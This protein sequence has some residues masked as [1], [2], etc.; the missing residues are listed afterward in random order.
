M[1]LA[2]IAL[3]L[4]HHPQRDPDSQPQRH[5]AIDQA[6][7]RALHPHLFSTPETHDAFDLVAD[8]AS[9]VARGAIGRPCSHRSSTSRSPAVTRKRGRAAVGYSMR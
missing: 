6:N 2:D 5:L 3:L 4:E 7:D 1:A 9:F 8:L